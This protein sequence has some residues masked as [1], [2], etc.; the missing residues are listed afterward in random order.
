MTATAKYLAMG[1]TVILA[2]LLAYWFGQR[3]GAGEQEARLAELES[4]QKALQDAYLSGSHDSRADLA[5]RLG[6]R[7]VAPAAPPGAAGD[8]LSLQL[9]SPE[10]QRAAT[11]RTF[12]QLQQH[13][14]SERL[15]AGWAG[16]VR[17]NVGDAIDI[18]VGEA[19]VSP[20]SSTVDCRSETCRIQLRMAGDADPDMLAQSLLTEIA[21]DLPVAQMLVLPG[22]DGNNELFIF[23]ARRGT[24]L[25]P[26][27]GP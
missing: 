23:A 19:G 2:V 25:P 24:K 16:G 17:Q 5:K 27:A 13:F 11:Q 12:D 22:P 8:A 3:Q 10:E 21:G 14:D 18:A 9:P 20:Q 4:Q 7:K 15:D 26:P 6:Y 1:G